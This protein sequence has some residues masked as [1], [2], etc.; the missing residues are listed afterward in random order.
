MRK[1]KKAA[2]SSAEAWNV[3]LVW[4]MRLLS[5]VC[6]WSV[7]ALHHTKRSSFLVKHSCHYK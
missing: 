3:N 2:E 5:F 4:C 1:D 6:P 7:H